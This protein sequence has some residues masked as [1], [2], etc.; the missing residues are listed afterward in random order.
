MLN[1][2]QAPNKCINVCDEILVFGVS[3]QINKIHPIV[4]FDHM[5]VT[6]QIQLPK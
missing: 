4:G 1:Q 2:F 3:F 6:R 5:G